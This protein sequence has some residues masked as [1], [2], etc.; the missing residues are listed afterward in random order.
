M[1]TAII[2]GRCLSYED[3]GGD[4][5]AVILG[6]GFLLDGSVFEHQMAAL[7]PQWR[8]IA[9]DARGH[10]GTP[11]AEVPYTYWDHARDALAVMD[12]LGI[13]Q[14]VVGGVSQGGFTALRTALLAPERVQGLILSDTEATACHPADKEGYGQ[15][16]A[17]LR[18]HGPI[19]DL[20]VQLSRQILGEHPAADEWRERWRHRSLPLGQAANCLLERDDVSGRL[21]EI[22][23][24]ALL[25][26]GS[27]D[28][29]L[30]R[31]RMELLA[32]RLPGATPVHVIKGAA[33]TPMLTH[34]EAANR[35][36][37]D[38]LSAV[39]VRVTR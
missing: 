21:A 35:V 27:E 18:E 5:P 23:C 24:P 29:S 2:D 15:M 8:V 30:P 34:A 3:T 7:S 38:F 37:V 22:T 11:D 6:H 1:P 39:P 20:V 28:Q 12:H 16:F 13:E 25:L 26:W 36:L 14:A 33:H 4:G 10:G 19:D 31:D 17:A 32:D 9:W